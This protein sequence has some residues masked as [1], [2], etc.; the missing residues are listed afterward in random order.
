MAYATLCLNS[1]RSRNTGFSPF[2]LFFSRDPVWCVDVLMGLPNATACP[3]NE[4]PAAVIDRMERVYHLVSRN[5]EDAALQTQHYYNRN[6]H[7]KEFTEGDHV[8]V[9]SPRR[10]KNRS[11]K[12]Q[13][14][15]NQEAFVLKCFND[16]TYLVKFVNSRRS[17]GNNDG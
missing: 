3:Q 1:V 12:W 6:V 7:V 14:M 13:S 15:Y 9:Y 16:V 5:V 4:Y 2:F 17:N 8:L 11:P 10:Y